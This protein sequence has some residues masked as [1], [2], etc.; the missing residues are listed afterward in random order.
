MGW[1]YGF[2]TDVAYIVDTQND[3][4]FLLA[5]TIEVN[6]DGIYNDNQYEYESIGLPFL[7]EIGR[8]VYA[9]ALGKGD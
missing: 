5:G 7:A 6:P 4:E 9:Y 1:A 8:L 3:I 2:L